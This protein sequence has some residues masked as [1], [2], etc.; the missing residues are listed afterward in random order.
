MVQV[1][2]LGYM[3]VGVKDSAAWKDFAATVV[4]FEVSDDG[5]ADRC[6]TRGD[7]GGPRD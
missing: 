6:A 7:P 2:E 3:G 1:T 4:G 5:E